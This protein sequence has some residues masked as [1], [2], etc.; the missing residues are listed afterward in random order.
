MRTS[1]TALLLALTMSLTGCV[2]VVGGEDADDRVIHRMDRQSRSHMDDS[3]RPRSYDARSSA[4]RELRARIEQ[5]FAADPLLADQR[6]SLS[7]D[8]DEV[9]L[10]GEVQ[11]L[12][13]FDRA[14]EV[15]SNTEGVGRAVSR[16]V[17]R[18]M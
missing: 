13:V 5:A 8:G 2:L 1:A 9:T 18:I 10:H 16:L 17:V 15:V 7:I 6:I 3:D 12:A 11:D 14:V 4:S